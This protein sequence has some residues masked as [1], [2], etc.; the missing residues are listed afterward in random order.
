M[1]ALTVSDMWDSVAPAWG[2]NADVVDAHLAAATAA[3]LDAA[4][5]A[6]GAAVLD[7]AAG[8]G[9]AG[10][11]AAERVGAAG[12]VVLADVA[13]GMVD[14]AARRSAGLAQVATQVFDE[15]T[16]DAPDGSFDAVL[17]RHG[18]MFAEPP[19]DAVREAARVLRP[20]GCYAV[21]TWA[22]REANPWL[23][24]ALDAVGQQFGVP[25]PPPHVAG[26]FSL[27]DP[28]LLA[29][30]LREGG[31]EDV[32]VTR[33]ETPWP[34]P[35]LTAWWERVPQLAG[36]LAQ[37]LA[38][39][40]ADVRDAIGRRALTFGAAAAR[41]TDDGGIVMDGAVLI[42]SGRRPAG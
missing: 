9:G 14:V 40:D 10:I 22:A 42:G 17:C 34:A 25:F 23:G 19:A 39:M 13:P 31:L 21:M 26:P 4:Q 7:V 32:R 15:L 41:A 2:R 30:V 3:L 29:A 8:P 18:L 27:D 6:A 11:A 24:L 38:G 28:E 1:L 12:R 5:I 33:M 37:A 16:I 20:G 36:P 35:S